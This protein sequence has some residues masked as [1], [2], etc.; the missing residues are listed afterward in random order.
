MIKSSILVLLIC[1][2]A[3]NAS[4]RTNP[5]R[6]VAHEV[7]STGSAMIHDKEFRI[8]AWTLV[9]AF[10]ADSASTVHIHSICSTC[11]ER[12]GFF[13]GT[14]NDVGISLAWGG[15]AAANLVLAHRLKEHGAPRW[16]W[17]AP[18]VIGTIGHARAA[19]GNSA[20]SN[21]AQALDKLPAPSTCSPTWTLSP[22]Y[23]SAAR[24]SSS[25]L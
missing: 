17:P 6:V 7:S 25:C 23:S 5:F 15:V 1:L 18:L 10:A 22:Q 13:N 14:Q 2:S 20:W 3:C 4:A 16:M 24:S 11:L 19:A 12:G 21:P 9:A 8:V